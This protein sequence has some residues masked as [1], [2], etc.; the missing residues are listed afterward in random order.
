MVLIAQ[1]GWGQAH[2]RRRTTE[3]GFD[4]HTVK[5]VEGNT[6]AAMFERAA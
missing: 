5:P 4:H 1:T 6:L 2:D 3:A